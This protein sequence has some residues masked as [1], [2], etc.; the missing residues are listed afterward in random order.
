MRIP[1]TDVR[2]RAGSNAIVWQSIVMVDP[3]VDDGFLS[4]A[5]PTEITE[6][7]IAFTAN[8]MGS[9]GVLATCYAWVDGPGELVVYLSDGAGGPEPV[10]VAAWRVTVVPDEETP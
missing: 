9:D 5:V 10:A 4:V 2:G 3:E 7:D 6:V 1:V 8:P